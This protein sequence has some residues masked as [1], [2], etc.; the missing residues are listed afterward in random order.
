MD[1]QF[2]RKDPRFAP[3]MVAVSVPKTEE[4]PLEYIL[5][6]NYPNPFNP[7][8]TIEFEIAQPANVTLTVFNTLGEE[9]STLLDNEMM[10]EG[11]HAVEFN[12]NGL[13]SGVYFYRLVAIMGPDDE[14]VTKPQVTRT[15]RMLLL[16]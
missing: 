2:L 6:Q 4:V 8:T 14:G 16:K 7:T 12:A 10:D 11:R 13:A 9:I 3:R 1:V 5:E 15:G